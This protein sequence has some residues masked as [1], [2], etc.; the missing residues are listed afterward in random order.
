MCGGTGKHKKRIDVTDQV[1][2]GNP[3]DECLPLHKYVCGHEFEGWSMII[4]IYE[5]RPK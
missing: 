5:D 2:F 1:D 4:S 3:D